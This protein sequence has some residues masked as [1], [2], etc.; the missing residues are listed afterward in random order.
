MQRPAIKQQI[1]FLRTNN[2]ERVLNFYQDILGFVLTL[3]QGN[4]LIFKVSSTGYI[5]FCENSVLYRTESVIVTLV[6][7]SVAWYC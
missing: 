1:T 6:V 5:G 2:F 3:D 4:C 7:K